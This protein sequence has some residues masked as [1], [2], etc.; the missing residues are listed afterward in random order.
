MYP[1]TIKI[2]DDKLFKALTEKNKLIEKGRAVS[3]EIEEIEKEMEV[4]DKEIQVVE[5]SVDLGEIEK[6]AQ[7]VTD[8]F[9]KLSERMSEVKKKISD[10]LMQEVPQDKIDAYRELDKKKEELEQNRNKIA[11]KAQKYTD[12]IIPLARNVMSKFIV[13]KYEDFESVKIEDGEIVGTIFNHLEDW[14]TN[15][16]KKG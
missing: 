11:L 4:I 7:E 8:E 6:E 2:E 14:K 3:V 9:N 16:D 12:K 15:F 13:D 10:K 5:K 1:K